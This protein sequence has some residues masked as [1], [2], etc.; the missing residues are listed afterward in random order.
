MPV[1]ALNV[2]CKNSSSPESWVL[3]VVAI[4]RELS[5]AMAAEGS[6][7]AAHSAS[8]RTNFIRTLLALNSDISKGYLFRKA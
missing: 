3:V 7:N 8:M 4:I 2:G 5:A 6:A 1:S